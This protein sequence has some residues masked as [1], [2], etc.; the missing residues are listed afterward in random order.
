MNVLPM[1]YTM[2]YQI[3]RFEFRTKIKDYTADMFHCLTL[4]L[5]Q[6]ARVYS[7]RDPSN[8]FILQ[9]CDSIVLPA[10]FGEYVCENLGESSCQI[11]KTLLIPE[12]RD[13]IDK[14]QEEKDWG[15][16]SPAG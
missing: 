15:S 16:M 13:H 10:C 14:A 9:D 6:R 4:T 1:Y 8:G 7:K 11:I 12:P 3:N 5:G 2:P